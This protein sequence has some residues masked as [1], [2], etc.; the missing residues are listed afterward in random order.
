MAL[1]VSDHAPLPSSFTARTCTSYFLPAVRLLN[2]V[3]VPVPVK[4]WLLQVE[5]PVCLY[6]TS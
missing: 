3:L 6:C 5:T 2:V 1:P 4:L